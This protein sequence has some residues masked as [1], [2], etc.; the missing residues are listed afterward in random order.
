MSIDP[1]RI[2]EFTVSI[3][4]GIFPILVAAITIKALSIYK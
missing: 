3:L 2:I 4:I 1:F